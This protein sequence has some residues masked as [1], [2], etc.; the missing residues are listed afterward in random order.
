[1][2]GN[3]HVLMRWNGMER[4]RTTIYERQVD[5]QDGTGCNDDKNKD[6]KYTKESADEQETK[7]NRKR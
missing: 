4:R 3:E 7:R 2:E 1:M 6:Q 5:S